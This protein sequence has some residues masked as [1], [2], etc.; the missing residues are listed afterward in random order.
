MLLSQPEDQEHPRVQFNQSPVLFFRIF[1][2]SPHVGCVKTCPPQHVNRY[3]LLQSN[4]SALKKSL[5]KSYEADVLQQMV[6]VS[7][8]YIYAQMWFWHEQR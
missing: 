1:P 5:A 3:V 7:T 4:P 2:I 8:H 6:D